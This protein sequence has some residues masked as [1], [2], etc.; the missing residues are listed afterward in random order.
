VK[1]YIEFEELVKAIFINCGFIIGD[2]NKEFKAKDGSTLELD[3]SITENKKRYA[4]EVKFYRSNVPSHYYIRAIQ[5]LKRRIV[6]LGFDYGVLVTSSTMKESLKQEV[7]S[8]GIVVIDQFDLIDMAS[9]SI[10]LSEKLGSMLSERK[11]KRSSSN[12]QS[13]SAT[14]KIKNVQPPSSNQPLLFLNQ[15]PKQKDYCKELSAIK[16]GRPEFSKYEKKCVEILK[17]LF[18]SHLT[19][20]KTQQ[21]TGDK[22]NRFDLVTRVRSESDFWKFLCRELGSR[23]IIFEFK[24][25]KDPIEQGEILTTEKYLHKTSLRTVAFMISRKGCSE[26][27][28]KFAQGA[29]REHGKL[30]IV[31]EDDELCKMLK[32]KGEGDDPSEYLFDKVD[33]F[34]MSLPR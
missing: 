31:L 4:V 8:S 21:G 5:V 30:I 27:A 16:P 26:N 33:E 29:M 7:E 6:E 17:Y 20:W 19:G 32:M 1:E 18:D 9:D 25:Y 10:E 15:P 13:Q 11:A 14:A 12:I 3:F 34:L 2:Q 23:Y 22:L 24:N 28:T